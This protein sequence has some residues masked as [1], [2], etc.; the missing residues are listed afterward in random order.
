[1]TISSISLRAPSK[2]WSASLTLNGAAVDIG[3]RLPTRS[4]GFTQK[5]GICTLQ[6]GSFP[7]APAGA[8][9]VVTLTL[10]GESTVFFTGRLAARPIR[11]LPLSYEIGLV[12]SLARLTA[13]LGHDL[14]WNGRAY[15]DAVRDLLHAAGIADGEIASIFTPGSDYALGP[16]V[17]ITIAKGA[18]IGGSL[19]TLLAFGGCGLFVLPNGQIQ[20]ADAPGWPAEPDGDTPVYAFGAST[21]EYG[22]I[23]ST[24]TIASHEDTVAAFTAKGPRLPNKTIPDATFT[25]A[26]VTGKTVGETFGYCQREATARAIAAREIVRRNRAA[27]EVD[28]SA[29]LN[30][31]LRPGQT[32]LFR[33]AELGIV[34]NTPA[35]IIG[36]TTS[37]DTMTMAVSVGARPAD[38]TF[39]AI[40]PPRPTFTMRYETQPVS[41]TGILAVATVVECTDTSTDPSGFGITSRRW[42]A[43]CSGD[44]QPQPATSSEANPVFIFPTLDG[45]T[46]ELTVESAS[47]EGA[48]GTQAVAPAEAE[49]FTRSLSVAAGADGWRI[50]AG[51]TGWRSYTPGSDCTAVPNINDQGPLLGGFAD[52]T[53]YRSTDRLLTAPDLLI[54][55]PSGAVRCIFV[56]EGNPSDV[57]VGAGK[58]LARSQDAGAS[59]SAVFVF[60]EDI[61]YCESSPTAPNEIRVCAGSGMFLATDGHTFGVP[62]SGVTG[63][64]CRKVASAPWGHLMIWSGTESLAEAWAFEEGHAIDWSGVP[65]DKMPVDLAAVTPMQD[66]EGY[67]VA[68]GNAADLVRDGLY[69]QLT[70]LSNT[71]TTTQLYQVVASGIGQFVARYITTTTLGGPHKVVNHGGAYPIDTVAQAHRIGYGAAINPARPPELVVLPSGQSGAA[72][73]LAHYIPTVG[74]QLRALPEAGAQW[75]GLDICPRNSSEWLIWAGLHI[76]WTANAGLTWTQV[77]TPAEDWFS[78]RRHRLLGVCFTGTGGEW[79]YTLYSTDGYNNVGSALIVGAQA[80]AMRGRI[81]GTCNW[82]HWTRTTTDPIHIVASLTRG[83]SGELWA[84]AAAVDTHTEVYDRHVWIDGDTLAITEVGE[85]PY[86]PAALRDRAAGRAGLAVWGTNIAVTPNYRA[87]VPTPVIAGGTSVAV[88]ALGTFVGGRAGLAQIQGIDTTPTLSVVTGGMTSVGRVVA[89]SLGQGVGAPAAAPNSDGTWTIFAHNGVQWASTETPAGMG[90]ICPQIGVIER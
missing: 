27:T 50:L 85:S 30:P 4:L 87:S 36:M 70:Y 88:C 72:D 39:S 19:D 8:A 20:V 68:S 15:G 1:M 16:V 77:F 26:G 31:N 40:P 56:N 67:I 58:L 17:P 34:A 66:T 48:V 35:V 25:L 82:P 37:D 84:Q 10:N 61:Q 79:A 73:Q 32:I 53:L 44:H 64:V 5:R 63:T 13:P 69:G 45:A 71:G 57:L 18:D 89:G 78:I 49:R 80:I 38:G 75:N 29:P 59:W 83:Y 21:D 60:E 23:S 43:A 76:Y 11:D 42:A 86:V 2:R 90:A 46:V 41:L 55:F 74:W 47:G 9:A 12:D 22:F 3:D 14:V 54:T 24:R 52:G 51:A 33:H 7:A 81:A 28:I 65:V 62:L 6:T